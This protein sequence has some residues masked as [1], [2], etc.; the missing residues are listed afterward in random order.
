M[1]KLITKMITAL[2]RTIDFKVY[3]AVLAL[4]RNSSSQGMLNHH[5]WIVDR[6]SSS[7]EML[8]HHEQT[9]AGMPNYIG[10]LLVQF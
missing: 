3:R 8:N 1:T 2:S 10:G 7:Q 6:N 5:E 9:V 4:D